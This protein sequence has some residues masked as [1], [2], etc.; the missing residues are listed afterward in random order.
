MKSLRSVIDSLLPE[1]VQLLSDLIAFPSTPGKEHEALLFLEKA[2]ASTGAR[3]ERVPLNDSLRQDPDYSDPI[4][5]IP[6]NGR[7]N[8]RVVRPGTGGGR[9][10]LFNAHTDVV[11]PSADQAAPWTARLENGLLHARGAC[12]AKGQVA[13][14]YLMLRALQE[15]GLSLK[16][17]V[18]AHIVVEEENGGNGTLAMARR[19][20]KADACIVLEPTEG[21]VLT[22]IRGAVWFRLIFH[23]KAGHSGQAGQTRSAL[24]LARDA[25]AALEKYHDDLLAASRGDP[26]FDA[27]PNPMPITFGRLEAG[28]WPASAPSLAVMEGVL[29]LLPNKTKEQVCGEM[30]AALEAVPSL[31][32]HFELTFLYRHDS[33]VL[34]PAHALPQGLMQAAAELGRPSKIDAMTASCDAWLYRNQLGIPTVV[35]GP[36]SLK[37]AHSKDEHIA[38]R[39]LADAAETLAAFLARHAGEAS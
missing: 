7:F 9:S 30:R 10:L 17:D 32:G 24:L 27:Y 37:V 1:T 2:F 15:S 8:L 11:P 12:D 28:N 36:G 21:R 26:L 4:P 19:G 29:G 22:A 35:Y 6:Y 16:G 18:L 34:E 5:D 38:V 3:V 23:G 31:A 14:V 13:T 25:I 39:D 33:S 20:E